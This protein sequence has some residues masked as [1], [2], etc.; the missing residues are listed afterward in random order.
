MYE[1]LFM[2]IVFK[3]LHAFKDLCTWKSRSP[4][5]KE[6]KRCSFYFFFFFFKNRIFFILKYGNNFTFK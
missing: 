5:Q 4:F 3:E 2:T 6:A 1:S